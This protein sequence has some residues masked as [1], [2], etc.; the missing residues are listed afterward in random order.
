MVE[1]ING[2]TDKP[3]ACQKL[4]ACFLERDGISGHLYVGYPFLCRMGL[5]KTS[6]IDCL[7]ISPEKGLVAFNLI[8]EA[9]PPDYGMKQDE[10]YQVIDWHLRRDGN[11]LKNRQVIVD[12]NVVTFAPNAAVDLC[13]E[14]DYPLCDEKTLDATLA[15]MVL[16]KPELYDLI[17]AY[18]KIRNGAEKILA[19]ASTPD[20]FGASDII[21]GY[22]LSAVFRTIEKPLLDYKEAHSTEVKKRSC[23]ILYHNQIRAVMETPDGTQR[24]RG[25]SGSGKSTVLALKAA[26]VHA[27]HPG[28]RI[29][30]AYSTLSA[31]SYYMNA[32]GFFY[33]ELTGMSPNWE[34]VTVC[35]A[36]GLENGMNGD[37]GMCQIFCAANF[38]RLYR[39][40]KDKIN[41]GFSDGFNKACEMGLYDIE[42][43]ERSRYEN[44]FDNPKE[45]FDILIIDEAQDFPES[46]LR[47]CYA[48]LRNPKRL[49][50]AYDEL[51]NFRSQPLPPPEDILANFN[52][53]KSFE[54]VYLRDGFKPN[55]DIVLGGCYGRPFAVLSAAHALAFGIYRAPRPKWD[56]LGLLQMLENISMWIALGYEVIDGCL[57]YGKRVVMGRASID[58]LDA[59][60]NLEEQIVFKAFRSEEEHDAWVVQEIK[61]NL[62]EGGLEAHD[63]MVVVPERLMIGLGAEVIRN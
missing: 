38:T 54:S 19:N 35:Q 20:F 62:A 1:V 46:F 49:V 16:G 42:A 59:D 17:R 40:S 60:P 24:I 3:L 57:D 58:R 48:M 8:E 55:S 22:A 9:V 41:L 51:Q 25:L 14:E 33:R 37:A 26:Y 7:L 29:G 5:L 43:R 13:G 50:F 61:R 32:I 44:V 4:I 6:R 63:I 28:W 2:Y 27:C 12:I 18:P 30:V 39:Y 23:L 45:I 11:L 31:R 15:D 10:V 56:E 53:G 52:D 21:L 34:N 36:W 47:L